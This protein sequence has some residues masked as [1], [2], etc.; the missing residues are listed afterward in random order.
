MNSAEYS[1]DTSEFQWMSSGPTSKCRNKSGSWAGAGSPAPL[2]CGTCCLSSWAPSRHLSTARDCYSSSLSSTCS[3][4]HRAQANCWSRPASCR[5]RLVSCSRSNCH[6]PRSRGSSC[7]S[8]PPSLTSLRGA[9]CN[10]V[11]FIKL[12]LFSVAC[13]CV[14]MYGFNCFF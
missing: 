13:Q 5:R 6:W 12:S 10:V 3:G 7:P 8:S 9:Y 11:D 1:S 2:S 14:T 4:W